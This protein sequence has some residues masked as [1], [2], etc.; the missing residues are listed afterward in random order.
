MIGFQ[1]R[2]E[3]LIVLLLLLSLHRKGY[4]PTDLSNEDNNGQ[5]G[6]NGCMTLISL[7]VIGRVDTA[8]SITGLPPGSRPL[9]ISEFTAL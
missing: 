9:Y 8:P 3:M 4:G 6:A 2:N 5:Q 7:G 1:M